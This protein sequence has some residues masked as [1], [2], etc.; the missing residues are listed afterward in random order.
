M[1]SQLLCRSGSQEQLSAVALTWGLAWH[2]VKIAAEVATVLT[3]LVDLLLLRG[4]T[5]SAV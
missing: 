3:G 1:A 4:L 2:A 5:P